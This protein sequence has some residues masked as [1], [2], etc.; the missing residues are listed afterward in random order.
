[1]SWKKILLAGT[2]ILAG[3]IVG[4]YI[5]LSTYDYTSLKPRIADIA[6]EVT[7]RELVLGE[8]ITLKFGLSPA[9]VL[10]NIALQ[11][12]SWGSRPDM[13]T[14]KRLEIKV[15]LLPLILGRIDIKRLVLI[16]P[17]ILIE[18]DRSGRSNLSFE[19]GRR[20]GSSSS[21]RIPSATGPLKLPA[22]TAEEVNIEQGQVVYRDGKTGKSQTVKILRLTAGADSAGT[23]IHLKLKSVYNDLPFEITATLGPWAAFTSGQDCLINLVGKLGK[24]DMTVKGFIKDVPHL[25]HLDLQVQAKGKDLSDLKPLVEEPLASQGPFE[26]A[27]RISD[28]SIQTYRVSD[29]K[30]VLDQSD[31]NGTVE[32]DLSKDRAMLSGVLTSKIVDLRPLLAEKSAGTASPGKRETQT[33][34]DEKVFSKTP[35]PLEALGKADLMV[36]AQADKILLPEIAVNSMTA[37]IALKGGELKI[38]P[39]KATVGGGALSGSLDIEPMPG[40]A[41]MKTELKVERLDVAR[42]MKERGKGDSTEGH[43]DV[44]ID[45]NGKGVSE[46][47]LMSRL[48]GRVVLT[49]SQGKIHNSYIDRLGGDISSTLFLLLNPF[50]KEADYTAVNCLVSGFNI[51]DGV[52]TTTAFALDTDE[53][54]VIGEGDVNLRTE[55]LNLSLK[56]VAKGGIGTGVTGKLSLS[57]DALARPF[58]LAGTLAHPTLGIDAT[59]AAETTAEAIGSI[60]LFG[61]AGILATLVTGSSGEEDLCRVAADAA[62]KGIKLSV[63]EEKTRGKGVV[64]EVTQGLEEGLGEIGKGLKGLFNK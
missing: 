26:T 12:A 1:M 11:N 44:N 55:E 41:L 46:A 24:I 14:V 60:A 37:D 9:L 56:P 32:V 31:L 16:Q 20:S 21:K 3:L 43:L 64:G 50:R 17:D 49:M 39:L 13:V 62:R 45:V 29:L 48:N 27:F 22:L 2:T 61:P 36:K 42:L 40:S 23:P 28:P 30:L 52:A 57:L 58:K 34:R 51:H 10:G 47:E 5:L 25:R 18:T 15:A 7:G 35:L 53:M 4:A 6:R 54:S 19:G 8:K 63:V 33:T 59:R 38:S